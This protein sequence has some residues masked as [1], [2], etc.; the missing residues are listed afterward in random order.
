MSSYQAILKRYGALILLLSAAALLAP[1]YWTALHTPATGIYHDDSIYL[2]T[3]R[4]MAE[5]RGYRIESI[6]EPIAQT[7]YP[8][9]FPGLLAVVWKLAPVFP[10]NV[11]YFKLIPLAAALIW[12]CLSYLLILQLSRSRILAA[13]AVA[14]TASS[15]QVVFFSTTVLSETLFA[16]LATAAI[17]FWIKTNDC[18][19]RTAL[20]V[21][22]VFAAAAYHTRTI[23]FCVI[24][25]GIL[26]FAWQRKW[27]EGWIF[28]AVAGGLASPW[29][30]WQTLN[31]NAADPYLSQENYYSA[32]NIVVSFGWEEK[33][34]I[35]MLNLLALPLSVQSFFDL[36]WGAVLGIVCLPLSLRALAGK[37]VPIIVRSFLILSLAVIL[38]WVWPPLRFLVPL[39]PLLIWMVWSGSPA[40]S[41]KIFLACCWLLFGQ[42]VWA[43]HTF[44]QAA[45]ESGFWSPGQAGKHEWRE[46]MREMDWIKANTLPSAIVQSNLDP[47]VYLFSN[48][49]AIRGSHQNVSLFW[50]LNKEQVLGR[51]DEFEK[52]LR[53]NQVQFIVEVPWTWFMQSRFNAELVSKL[54]E[55]HPSEFKLRYKSEVEGFRI[56]EIHQP[57]K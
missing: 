33:I 21:S 23:G 6:P 13:T 3:A 51:P 40:M 49:K 35:A 7:K 38:M 53:Q 4:T 20:I 34:R 39:M 8:I 48:R 15:P 25:A 44:S 26:S 46:F 54:S 17:L 47:T 52:T 27:R 22:A 28:A 29:I 10:S 2:I 18:G 30:V 11:L 32:Y 1:S 12:F 56:F 9:L 36:S 16:A 42:G 5:G 19:S 37:E 31:R 14:L 50:Y 41:K 24:L 43:S 45:R 55:L 57:Q